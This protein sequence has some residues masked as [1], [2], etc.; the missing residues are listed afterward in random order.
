MK[1]TKLF[2]VLAVFMLTVFNSCTEKKEYLTYIT[3]GNAYIFKD[4]IDVSTSEWIWNGDY[5]RYE[6]VKEYKEITPEIFESA[7]VDVAM[8]VTEG[9]F[10]VRK[11]L[12]FSRVFEVVDNNGNVIGTYTETFDYD[13][14]YE[15]IGGKTNGYIKFVIQN[16]DASRNDNYLDKQYFKVTT[17]YDPENIY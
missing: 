6:A 3:G 4:Q 8:F 11:Q 9:G 16:S 7:I 15:E 13:I 14:F 12:P 1:L 5:I 17:V 10:A 2:V